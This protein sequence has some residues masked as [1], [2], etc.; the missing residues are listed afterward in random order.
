MNVF[1]QVLAG[2]PLLLLG[3]ELMQDITVWEGMLLSIISSQFGRIFI[4]VLK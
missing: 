3:M 1:Y 2:L 4:A